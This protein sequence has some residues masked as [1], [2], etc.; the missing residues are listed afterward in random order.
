[1]SDAILNQ[2]A[3]RRGPA[4][5]TSPAGQ[6]QPRI[7]VISNTGVSRVDDLSAAGFFN[8]DDYT[9][10][11][12]SICVEGGASLWWYW[13]DD[14]AGVVDKTATG[15]GV[16]TGAFLPSGVVQDER[17]QGR[18]LVTQTSAAALV[19]VWLSSGKF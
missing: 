19:H 11:Y 3:D 9:D 12:V 2:A 16:T 15:N 18:Y 13:T 8:S 6:F 7:I 14:V 17:P 1:M 5:R 10:R 4:R